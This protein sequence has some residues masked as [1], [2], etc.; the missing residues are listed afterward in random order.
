MSF[1][2]NWGRHRKNTKLLP[3]PPKA[4]VPKAWS[5]AGGTTERWLACVDVDP[6]MDNPLATSH[7]YLLFETMIGISCLWCLPLTSARLQRPKSCPGY[8]LWHDSHQNWLCH[9]FACYNQRNGCSHLDWLV[10]SWDLQ[11]KLEMTWIKKHKE[12]EVGTQ[13][14]PAAPTTGLPYCLFWQWWGP[15]WGELFGV[16]LA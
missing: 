12:A 10:S 5:P 8:F 7:W 1:F 15:A 11:E 13:G 9:D 6:S 3:S 14:I 2:G 16:A 4:P